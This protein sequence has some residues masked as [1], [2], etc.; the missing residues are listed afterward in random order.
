MWLK[1]VLFGQGLI[2]NN[3]RVYFKLSICYL[4]TFG[5]QSHTKLLRY[6]QNESSCNEV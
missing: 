5:D 1:P 4:Y 6:T 2:E 3:V